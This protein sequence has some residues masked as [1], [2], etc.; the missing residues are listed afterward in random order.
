M[1]NSGYTKWLRNFAYN[2]FKKKSLNNIIGFT[3]K[4]LLHKGTV[5]ELGGDSVKDC[6]ELYNE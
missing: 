1:H 5:C 2:N 4:E 3:A 6:E